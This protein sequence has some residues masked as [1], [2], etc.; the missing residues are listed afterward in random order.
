M[1]HKDKKWTAPRNTGPLNHSLKNTKSTSFPVNTFGCLW[2]PLFVGTRGIKMQ[3][4]MT[5]EDFKACVEALFKLFDDFKAACK[6]V[7]GKKEKISFP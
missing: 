2:T 1:I 6:L 4:N 7:I 5:S 3:D